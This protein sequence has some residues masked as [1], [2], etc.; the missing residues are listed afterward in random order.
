MRLLCVGFLFLSFSASSVGA[1]QITY[2]PI[3]MKNDWEPMSATE[4]QTTLEKTSL[5]PYLSEV[6]V[7]NHSQPE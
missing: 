4:K 5:K 3:S 2:P 7:P 1:Q 6:T